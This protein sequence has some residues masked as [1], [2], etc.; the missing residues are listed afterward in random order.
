MAKVD[1]ELAG[2]YPLAAATDAVTWQ[3]PTAVKVS[4]RVSESTVQPVVPAPETTYVMAPGLVAEAAA[5]TTE[6]EVATSAVE[7]NHA[8]PAAAFAMENVTSRTPAAYAEVA[9]ALARTAQVPA[10]EYVRTPVADSTVQPVVPTAVTSYDTTAPPSAVA[11]EDGVNGEAGSVTAV[12]GDH[13]TVCTARLT[14]KVTSKEPAAYAVVAAALAR[15]VH[16]PVDEYVSTPVVASTEQ[17][18]LPADITA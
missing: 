3:E 15:T 7:G 2:S 18:V 12:V 4:V 10:A 14:E 13:V 17:P 6:P 8:S 11:G 9:A 5:K 1:I 16:E